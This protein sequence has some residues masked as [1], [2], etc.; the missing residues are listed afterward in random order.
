VLRLDFRHDPGGMAEDEMVDLV[1]ITIA[2]VGTLLWVALLMR[3]GQYRQKQR[4]LEF[5]NADLMAAVS[6][7][8]QWAEMN[9]AIYQ[10]APVS[11]ITTDRDG[12]ITSMNRAAARMCGY[13]HEELVGTACMTVLH[14]KKELEGRAR[15]LA[16]HN[17]G[18]AERDGFDVLTATSVDDLQ[19][20]KWSYLRKDGSRVP[21]NVV[22]QAVTSDTTAGGGVEADKVTGFIAIAV[23]I[24]EQKQL[25]AR[26][27]QMATHDHLTKL[28]GRALLQENTAQA[29]ERARRYG[30]QV[31]VFVLDLDQMKRINDSLG[32]THGDKVFIEVARRLRGT[33]RSSDTVARVGGDEFV[34][35]MPD[36]MSLED[37]EQCGINLVQCIV[38]AM[39]I[40]GHEVHVTASVGACVYPDYAADAKHL[41]KRADV[42]MYAAKEGGRNQYQMFAED[43]LKETVDRLSMEHVLRHAVAN[44]ELRLEY[45]PQVSLSKGVVVG[46]EAL[47]RWTHPK[48]GQVPPSV[49]IPLAEETGLIVP[50]GTWV[51]QTA[52]REGA[53]LRVELGMDL[54]I[55][56]NLSPRQFQQKDLIAVIEEA[57][58]G[59][60]LPAK[61]LEI[62]ITETMVMVNSTT[63]LKTLQQIRNL[64]VKIAI[65]DFGTGFCSFTYLLQYQVDRLKIDQSF[66]RQAVYDTNAAAVVRT[67]IA[68]SHGLGINVVAEG[69]ETEEQLRFLMRRRC[70]EAQGRFFSGPIAAS[71]FAAA[72]ESVS[73]AQTSVRLL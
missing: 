40:D 32:Y 70:D 73:E 43:M 58:R 37:A 18:V 45:Q 33:V 16:Q 19:G 61:S 34:V 68:M 44:G 46:M 28:A 53:R 50:I 15:E 17:G 49:F 56:V 48:L 67:I 60:G 71:E 22:M 41:L 20:V 51:F 1:A 14:D 69:V 30:T 66:V 52:C 8:Q 36:I 38:P 12:L 62:E 7:S 13:S 47:L 6:R 2:T 59:S 63:T 11:M 35:V 9:E 23:D 21:V 26:M 31:A 10:N 3:V 5:E 65:D 54:T 72:V 24:S 55:S 27:T 57:L 29:V 4:G 39:H 25:L 42:A 64:G